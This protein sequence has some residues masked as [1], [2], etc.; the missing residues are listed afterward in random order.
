MPEAIWK[1]KE[2]KSTVPTWPSLAYALSLLGV[3]LSKLQ[4]YCDCELGGDSRDPPDDSDGYGSVLLMSYNMHIR[5]YMWQ[6][7][8]II[9]VGGVI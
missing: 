1:A 8:N 5:I 7:T 9:N 2:M 3:T 6:K 4:L